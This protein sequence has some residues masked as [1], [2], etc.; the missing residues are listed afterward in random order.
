LKEF[1]NFRSN[2]VKME[3]RADLESTCAALGTYDG[4]KYQRDDECIECVKDLIRFLRRDDDSHQLR[5]SLGQIGV[6]QSDLI[7]LLRDYSDDEELLELVL[8]L[9]VN[10]TGPE[11]LLFREELPQDK[12]TR[13]HFIELQNHRQAYKKAF[14]D[15]KLWAVL[16]TTLGS[17]LRK[18]YN[19][20]SEDDGLVIERILILVR[21][22]L[23]VPRDVLG[24][25]RT[26]DE[27]SIHDQVLWVL[28]KSGMEDLMLFIASSEEET[29]YCLHVLE[30][31]SL[32][33][34][35]QD[36]NHLASANFQRSKEEKDQDEMALLRLRESE[37]EKSRQKFRQIKSTRHSRF[38][39]TFTVANV[40]SIS[41]RTLIIHQPLAA[42]DNINFDKDKRPKKLATNKR[43]PGDLDS[44]KRRSTLAI[45]LFLKEFCVELL[46]GAYNKLMSV[47]KDSLVRQKAQN[48][49]E[50]YY[51]WSI[52][53]FME[54]NRAYKFRPDLVFETLNKSTFHYCQNQIEAYKDSFEHEKR[55]RPMCIIWARRIH[56]AVRAYQELLLNVTVM[57]SSK[58]DKVR[59]SGMVLRSDVFYESEYREL[60]LQQLSLYQP[61]KMSMSHLKDIVETTHVFLKLMEHMSKSSHVMVSSKKVRKKTTK[62]SGG[63]KTNKTTSQDG[64]VGERE[65]NEQSWD[66]V[67]SELSQIL[68]GRVNGGELPEIVAPF[69]ATSDVKIDDQRNIAMLRIQDSLR[70]NIPGI[71]VALLRASREVWPENDAFGANDAEPE[72]EYI[73]MREILFADIPR[74]AGYKIDVAD[75]APQVEGENENILEQPEIDE[76]DEEDEGE[77]TMVTTR[78]EQ[79][80]DFNSFLQRFA[81]QSVCSAYAI[82]FANYDKNTDHTNHCIIKMFHRIAWDMKLP[83]LL[84]HVAILRVFQRIHRD[85]KLAPSNT[86]FR[87]LNRFAKFVLEKFFE[88][89]KTNKHI[90]ME[91]CFWKNSREASEIVDGYGTQASTKSQKASFW[92]EED[93]EK[94]IR[95]FTQLKEMQTKE[96]DGDLLD[97]ITAFF[98]E[99][100]KSRRQVATKL[101]QMALIAV[102][103]YFSINNV[104]IDGK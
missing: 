58:D 28:H 68:Q 104:P 73:A 85:Y 34:R 43:T 54:F 1:C 88:V 96:E 37:M 30:I 25:R 55:N 72:D 79:E 32:M 66:V 29:Q 7:P 75:Q 52:K 12:V 36:P 13:N 60:C 103:F 59:Q 57:V 81:V 92:C 47:V 77:E 39:G 18:D 9:M 51:L 14:V 95:V 53:F 45:R 99:A 64:F 11:L 63:G 44:V 101:K 91:S 6:V 56:L 24:E 84:F 98:T 26:D 83:A 62:K 74:P 80:F 49:D 70:E 93:E 31:I 38:G 8:R 71:A 10:L 78:V 65:T 20:R 50:T 19:D 5:R 69:D 82:L 3:W 16:T 27:A 86:S 97:S 48:N 76:E 46:H 23:Q 87:E 67:S 15:E 4:I 35:E 33:F 89:A 102:R 42:V 21:N 17:L 22:V 90:W 2:L 61:E 40:K 94:L 100:G 41:E